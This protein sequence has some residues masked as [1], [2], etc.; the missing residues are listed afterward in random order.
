[1]HGFKKGFKKMMCGVGKREREVLGRDL[2]S[3]RKIDTV[4]IIDNINI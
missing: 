2:K 3:V 1:M 4:F